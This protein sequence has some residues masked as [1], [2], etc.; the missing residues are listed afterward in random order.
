MTN[1]VKIIYNPYQKTIRY[2]YR[3]APNQAW[4]DLYRGSELFSEL[5][6]QQ[7]SLQNYAEEIIDYILKDCCTDGRGVDLFFSGTDA[8]WED[9]KEIVRRMDVKQQI[10]CCDGG[11]RMI[12][13]EAA[14]EKIDEIFKGLA[15]DFADDPEIKA[16]LDKYLDASRS[17]VVLV[18]AGAYSAGK[19]SFINA[20]IGE[21]LLPT[22]SSPTTAKIFKV[23]SLPQGT[24][25]DTVI[26]FQYG[27]Q[28]V[29][30]RF[31]QDGY[32]LED[33]AFLPDL[34]LKR[35]LDAA[36]R[37]VG[38][39]P[40][41]VCRLISVLNEFNSQKND[42]ADH[43]IS[44]WIEIDTPFVGSTLPLDRYQF[45]IC[46]TPG[47][48]AAKHIEH[49]EA[50]EK[51]LEGQTNGLP[52][53]LTE[54]DHMSSTIV[55]KLWEQLSGIKALDTSNIM[56]V[57]NKAD[58]KGISTLVKN[59]NADKEFGEQKNVFFVSSVVGLGAKKPNMDQCIDE[60]AS[61][62]FDEKKPKFIRNEKA[63]LFL[64]DKLP[65]YRLQPICEAGEKANEGEDMQQRLLHN[66]GLW[67]VENEISRFAEKYAAYNKSQQAQTYL[68]SAIRTLKGRA[69]RKKMEK[70]E[71]LAQ[72]VAK[73]SEKEQELVHALEAEKEKRVQDDPVEYEKQMRAQ[74]E[75]FEPSM[76]PKALKPQIAAQW[77]QL[78]KNDG[79]MQRWITKEMQKMQKMI[80]NSLYSESHAFWRMHLNWFTSNCAELVTE[81]KGLS[82]QQKEFL[83]EHIINF[84][85]PEIVEVSFDFNA[86][87]KLERSFFFFWHWSEFDAKT[88]ADNMQKVLKGNITKI[89]NSYLDNVQNMMNKW[90][91]SFIGDLEARIADFNP[92]LQELVR[93]QETCSQ[94][95]Q[96][97]EDLNARF[98]QTQE[99]IRRLFEL[100]NE[101]V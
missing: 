95:I 68:S 44:D 31:N 79:A 58:L 88:C 45:T 24:W 27:G 12:S 28:S 74:I 63:R 98:A 52:L 30:I 78:K 62:T 11:G 9:L 81:S 84:P 5:K 32:Y 80:A 23:T 97:L 75:K 16:D 34:E 6:Y 64:A 43:L 60:D 71:L 49:K 46:D 38:P 99:E 83:R 41:Y 39:S 1:Q 70:A 93:Q 26:R 29:Q 7:G 86:L 53:L 14:L 42:S 77:K 21:E 13:S 51:A 57:V 91:D 19:S 40:A 100:D 50:M 82:E 20:L 73:M 59:L 76:A 25:S 8:D 17:G 33:S 67:A 66:S 37:D 55:E 48:N 3:S 10:C 65:E 90:Y 94:E 56:L 61:D 87:G 36:L 101:E 15:E 2:R 96:H 89:S 4:G 22:A 47:P 54:P 69:E 18:V 72:I 92:T 85:Q 35:R